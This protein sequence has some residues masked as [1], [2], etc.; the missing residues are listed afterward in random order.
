MNIWG[1]SFLAGC[2]VAIPV[3]FMSDKLSKRKIAEKY[4]IE[5][6]IKAEPDKDSMQPFSLS[7]VVQVLGRR[8]E[9][10][11]YQHEIK[12]TGSNT[13]L[14]SLTGMEDTVSPRAIL[15]SNGRV[16]FR[17][18]YN[19]T[20]LSEMLTVAIEVMREMN[21]AP[22]KKVPVSAKRDSMSKKVSDLLDSI[23][24][25]EVKEA[26]KD[27]SLPLI[28]FETTSYTDPASGGTRYPASLGIVKLKDTATVRK[29]FETYKI[30]QL[31]PADMQLCFGEPTKKSSTKKEDLQI[32]LYF[33]KTKGRP[34][35]APLE[36]EDVSD[37]A[38][39]FDQ[40]GKVTIQLQFNNPGT[41]K[42]ATMTRNNIGRSIA[43]IINGNVIS[44]PTVIEAILDGSSS[45]T[46]DYSVQEAQ[47]LCIGL[48]SIKIPATLTIIKASIKQEKTPANAIRKLLMTFLVFAVS[49][50]LAFFVFKT[51]KST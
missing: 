47:T 5:Y 42:W 9:T 41:R 38:Q 34:A 15:T 37:A 17:E 51:L 27:G 21:P 23:E 11:A 30:K 26:E 32:P 7:K 36:N 45:I 33:L 46:G 4:N 48:R 2:V 25:N 19:V 50:G 20:E 18:V 16:Q 44:A 3:Y 13:L 22:V 10:A 6:S 1:K 40:S 14:I 49:S 24:L 29:L 39:S 43:I 35:K 8:L 28:E 12:I 31:S